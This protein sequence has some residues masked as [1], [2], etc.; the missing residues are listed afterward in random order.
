M[1]IFTGPLISVYAEA[2]GLGSPL[3]VDSVLREI[4]VIYCM[5]LVVWGYLLY[6]GSVSVVRSE[7]SSAGS[8]VL[9]V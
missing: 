3:V 2:I 1:N 4:A 5:W 8:L 6:M 9:G 7:V